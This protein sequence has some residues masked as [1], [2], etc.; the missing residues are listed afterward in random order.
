LD[1]LSLNSVGQR[2]N[3]LVVALQVNQRN[4]CRLTHMNFGWILV[5]GGVV[6]HDKSVSNLLKESDRFSQSGRQDTSSLVGTRWEVA[7]MAGM[8]DAMAGR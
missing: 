7:S 8:G 6:I 3:V 1:I 4:I 2:G 5:Q